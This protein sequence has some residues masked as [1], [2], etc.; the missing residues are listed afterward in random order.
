MLLLCAGAPLSDLKGESQ[1]SCVLLPFR[2][3][4]R[5]RRD[6]LKALS[7]L[8]DLAFGGDASLLTHAKLLKGVNPFSLFVVL[9]L[10]AHSLGQ[11]NLE[12]PPAAE[13][14]VPTSPPPFLNGKG[15]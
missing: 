13:G 8:P 2:A 5:R 4:L 9:L 1:V 11:R 14:P 7:C 15:Y 12:V 6:G 3:P 10:S